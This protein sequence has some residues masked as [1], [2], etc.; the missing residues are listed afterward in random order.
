[1]VNTRPDISFVV[2]FLSQFI[3]DPS[4]HHHQVVQ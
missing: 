2:Q 3:Q 1:L 4:K